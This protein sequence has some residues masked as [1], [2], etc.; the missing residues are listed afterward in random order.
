[1]EGSFIEE[2]QKLARID[3]DRVLRSYR[4]MNDVLMSSRAWGR[5]FGDDDN[6]DEAA[7]RAQMY[8]IRSAIL[9]VEDSRERLLLYHYYV[10]GRTLEACAK[11]L[12]V[13]RRSIYRIKV[14]AIDSITPKIK[15]I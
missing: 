6:L 3:C 7:M 4:T 8:A 11:I 1:M 5:T 13:S 12:G 2:K 10:K 14:K 15:L 9:E